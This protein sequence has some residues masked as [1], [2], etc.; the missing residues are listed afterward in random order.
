M[1]A[2]S[3]GGVVGAVVLIGGGVVAMMSSCCWWDRSSIECDDSIAPDEDILCTSPRHVFG[4]DEYDKSIVE[5]IS[6]QRYIST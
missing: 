6:I 5:H 1:K 2:V 3:G 4:D